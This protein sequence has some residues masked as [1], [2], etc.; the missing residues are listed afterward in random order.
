M[1]KKPPL[2]SPGS[3]SPSASICQEALAKL[4]EKSE[5]EKVE[6]WELMRKARIAA[7]PTEGSAPHAGRDVGRGVARGKAGVDRLDQS[8]GWVSSE[9]EK[10]YRYT[11][12]VLGCFLWLK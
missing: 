5:E 7:L 4:E 10:Q 6:P 9:R 12:A 3:R 2:G 8:H 11:I 1:G